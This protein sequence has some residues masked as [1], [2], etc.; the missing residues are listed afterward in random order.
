[1]NDRIKYLSAT[2]LVWINSFHTKASYLKSNVL[3]PNS[4]KFLIEE[5][6]N[7]NHFPTLESKAALYCFNIITRHLFI[8][9]NK[10][11]GISATLWFLEMNNICLK[12]LSSNNIVKIA[13]AVAT[14]KMLLDDIARLVLTKRVPIKKHRRFFQLMNKYAPAWEALA[15][16]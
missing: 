12:Q 8:D 9:G 4:F 2:S 14:H 7:D 11:T 10:R 3:N 1:M 13:T 16:L 5:V 6:K 15:I